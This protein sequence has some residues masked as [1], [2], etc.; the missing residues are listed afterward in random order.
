MNKVI[1]FAIGII[2]ISTTTFADAPRKSAWNSTL[3]KNYALKHALKPN[4]NYIYF[5]NDCTNFISQIM[6]AGGWKDT[7]TKQSTQ[8]T[9]WFYTN[10]TSYAQTWSTA[11]GLRNRLNNGYEIGAE[12]LTRSI[13]GAGG[14]YLN[15]KIASGDIVFADWTD[16]GRFD[17]AMSVIDKGYLDT[18]VAYHSSNED[19]GSMVAISATNPFAYFEAF[20]IS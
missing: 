5:S 9:S 6:R 3:A 16:D 12:K 14:V 10:G 8:D 11:Q 20:H 4:P 15:N 2:F 19:N 7:V 18:R 1:P 17:H 13:G